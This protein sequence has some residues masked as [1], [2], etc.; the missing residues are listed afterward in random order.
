MDIVGF[1]FKQLNLEKDQLGIIDVKDFCAYIA[2]KKNAVNK[3]LSESEKQK[4]K[5][6]SVK[7]E[8]AR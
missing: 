2:V 3:I 6:K 5:G 8:L 1:F 4:I 7:I